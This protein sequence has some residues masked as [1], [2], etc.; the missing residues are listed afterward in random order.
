[1]FSISLSQQL[2]MLLLLAF[3]TPATLPTTQV[4]AGRKQGLARAGRGLKHSL[5][6][7]D[8]GDGGCGCGRLPLGRDD[9]DHVAFLQV[10]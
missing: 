1:M 10:F 6:A 3:S 9:N 2:W 4:P 8:D 5:Y 7:G